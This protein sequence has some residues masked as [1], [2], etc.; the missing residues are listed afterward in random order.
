LAERWRIVLSDPERSARATVVANVNDPLVAFAALEA[1]GLVACAVPV[2]WLGDAASCPRCTRALHYGHDGD[3]TCECGLQ[4]PKPKVTLD[5]ELVLDGV[6]HE[7]SLRLPGEFNRSNAALAVAAAWSC[8]VDAAAALERVREVDDVA[9]R[10][11]I[12]TYRGRKFRLMLAKNPAGVT[13]LL[14]SLQD[15][16]DDVVVSINDNVADGHDPSWLYD[17]PFDLLRG[18]RVWCHGSRDLDLAARLECD[19]VQFAMVRDD[20]TFPTLVNAA[21][22]VDVIANYTAFAW[23]MSHSEAA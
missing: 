5:G 14:G 4:R 12:R 3:W 18:R 9:G 15:G 10:F 21:G 13:A 22:P 8:G 20:E 23:W 11:D 17:A 6:S 1:R 16:S 2:S 19:G 7:L